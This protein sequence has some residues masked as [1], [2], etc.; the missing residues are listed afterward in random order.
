MY[1]L[2]LNSDSSPPSIGEGKDAPSVTVTLPSDLGSPSRAKLNA[3][4]KN[5]L[6]R[7]NELQVEFRIYRFGRFRQKTEQL[8]NIFKI[9]QEHESLTPTTSNS[10]FLNAGGWDN[11]QNAELLDGQPP[12]RIARISFSEPPEVRGIDFL[13]S[14]F[15][16]LGSS[17]EAI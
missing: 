11:D 17:V 8:T 7:I 16:R 3:L 6:R 1:P 2:F 9:L 10:D 13:F 12:P 4:D 5:P 15:K 14:T